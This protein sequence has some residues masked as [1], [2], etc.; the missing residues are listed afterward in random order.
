MKTGIVGAGFT[1]LSAAYYLTR[2]GHDVT[3]FEKDEK[4]GGLA[5]GYQEK[6]W[7]WTL[8]NHYHHWF[9][10]DRSVLK[11]AKEINHKVIIKRPK[12]SSFVDNE[13]FQFDSPVS[14]LRFPKLALP[15]KIRMGLSLSLLRYNPVWKPLEN[16]RAESYLRFSMGNYA[17]KKLWEPLMKNKLGQYAKDISL[18]WFWARV[19]K[20][21]S[22][23]A[24]PEGGFLSFAEHLEKEIEKKGGNF[25]YNTEVLKLSSPI[26]RGVTR[27]GGP[28]SSTRSKLSFARTSDGGTERQ[29][30]EQE[31][32]DKVIVTLPSF[33]FVKIAPQLPASYKNNLLK[34]EGLGA[35]NLVLRLKK[36]FLTDGTY[37]LSMCDAKSPILAIVEHTN[38]MDKKYY[39]NEHIVY[40]GNYLSQD[41]PR[42]QMTAEQ[43]LKLYDT[44]LKKIN[45]SYQLSVGSCQLFKTPFAQPIIPTN[46]SKILPPFETPLPNVYLANIQQVYPWDRGTNYAVELGIKVARL[47]SEKIN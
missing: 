36:Q 27:S 45:P 18:A 29:D 40:L 3:V 1:G 34:L 9:T 28:P 10:N 4:P 32:F 22:S 20:R 35:L 43:L 25:H 8:E 42:F 16:F 37:W 30:P 46:Y 26:R 39:N 24:Y 17:Y 41:D 12:T 19:Y 6:E 23:L 31:E 13:I 33:F 15:D 14:L 21:T 11:L 38:F 2:E 44:W 47:I 5:V 7:R